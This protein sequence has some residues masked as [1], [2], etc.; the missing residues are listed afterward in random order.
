[1]INFSPEFTC[2][3]GKHVVTAPNNQ[4]SITFSESASATF[5]LKNWPV[6]NFC[7]RKFLLVFCI[8]MLVNEISFKYNLIWSGMIRENINLLYL[9]LLIEVLSVLALYPYVRGILHPNTIL[10]RNCFGGKSILLSHTWISH[11]FGIYLVK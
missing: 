4:N 6:R 5:S 10:K 1:V 8:F 11:C 9:H 2:D 7:S 3:F